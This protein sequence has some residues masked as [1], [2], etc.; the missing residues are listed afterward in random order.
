[1]TPSSPSDSVLLSANWLRGVHV[2]VDDLLHPL[3][4]AE[5]YS[6]LP[7]IEEARN[8]S[9]TVCYDRCASV[10]IRPEEGS[11]L[12]LFELAFYSTF[13]CLVNVSGANA[14][15]VGAGEVSFP[16][17]WRLSDHVGEFDPEGR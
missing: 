4:L 15:L 17:W 9:I 14:E 1:M 8:G 6:G 16:P 13:R 10:R 5:Q 11:F 3:R 7:R 12:V 2:V